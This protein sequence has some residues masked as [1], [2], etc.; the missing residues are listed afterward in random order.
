MARRRARAWSSS[1]PVFRGD[2]SV[3][4][5]RSLSVWFLS[6][7]YRREKDLSSAP[8]IR[9]QDQAHPTMLTTADTVGWLRRRAVTV[10]AVGSAPE[11]S[12]PAGSGTTR[13]P[14]AKPAGIRIDGMFGMAIGGP[15]AITTLSA[16]STL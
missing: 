15:A 14:A 10:A 5:R 8:F 1:I 6:L 9:S 7:G 12:R 11:M 13:T 4:E 2:H 16:I 3:R